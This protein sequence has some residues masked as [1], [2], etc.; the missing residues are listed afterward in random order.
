[1][2][3]MTFNLINIASIASYSLLEI[4]DTLRMLY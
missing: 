3:A 2:H 4:Y 1:M